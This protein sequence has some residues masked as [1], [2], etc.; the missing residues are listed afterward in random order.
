MSP[1]DLNYNDP[2]TVPPP[3]FHAIH[4]ICPSY[5]LQSF[6]PIRNPLCGAGFQGGT[7]RGVINMNEHEYKLMVALL[8]MVAVSGFDDCWIS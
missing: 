3:R 2:T 1:R 5:P 4:L 7:V 6:N 8:S